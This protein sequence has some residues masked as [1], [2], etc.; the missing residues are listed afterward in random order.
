MNIETALEHHRAGRFAEAV[1]IYQQ[2]LQA[3]PDNADALH[4]LG[5][6]A[7]QLGDADAAVALISKAHALFPDNTVYLISLGMAYRQQRNFDIAM[8]CYE[9]VLEI[10][11]GSAS[12]YFG[13]ANTLQT[14]GRLDEAAQNFTYAL[15][16]NPGFVEARFNLANLEKSRGRYREA[17][18]HYRL[19]VAAKPDFADA[20][21][22]LGSALYAMGEA[23][24]ALA[25]YRQ[26]LGR[27]LPETHNNIGNIHF[28]CGDF[29]QALACYRQ[30][31]AAKPAYAEA[32]NNLGNALRKLGRFEESA[33]AFGEALRIQ[34][35]YATAHLNL[36]DLLLERDKVDEAAQHYQQAIAAA[37]GMAQA[38]FDLGVAR[39]LQDDPESAAACFAQAA[40]LSPDNIDAIYNLG[41]VCAKL[42]RPDEA[43]R[44]YRRVLELD[45]E[46]ID[47]HVNLSAL[48]TEA[49][50]TAEARSH[51][52]FA[53]RRKNL[54]E[55]RSPQAIKTVLLL[56][57]AGKGNMN[58]THLFNQKTNNII[59]W[60]V[61][62]AP[63]GQ[64]ANLPHYDLAFNAMGDPDV[65]GDTTEAVKR[66]LATTA[67]PLL[68]H[69]DK[70]ARTARDKLPA[71]LEGIPELLVPAVWRFADP[72]EWDPSLADRLPLLVR[73]VHTHGG[74]GMVLATS[75][76]ELARCR[77]EQSGPVYV[78]PFVDYRSPDSWFRKYRMIFI[79]RKPYPYH[80][81]V[82]QKWMVHYVT[83]D[84]EESPWRLAE[85][86]A[87]LENPEALVGSANMR[88]IRTIGERMDLDYAGLDFSILA[89]GRIL[90]FEANPTMLVHPEK[91]SGPLAHKN[92]Y[93][94]RIFG[95][96]EELL[97]R[98]VHLHSMGT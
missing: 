48:L 67:K 72:G 71:L 66:F 24:E 32:W 83:A 74:A 22:N 6:A 19:A 17:V 2:I 82:S 35:D 36:G 58:L 55:R 69:P 88:A 92:A 42:T 28:D 49:G 44:S 86:K 7:A 23:D 20:W 89:D 85:E 39:N 47:A 94:E 15:E 80:L 25:S 81:A 53:Y 43:E 65:T 38:H 56:L 87:Y 37:P 50:R 46:H 34:P 64:I 16:S 93:V 61:E 33:A 79:D 11:P 18:E 9:R 77:T 75:A 29:G 54:F 52:D 78:S 21:H 84:M 57:D 95:D 90:V 62:Y 63:P 73:P 70:V 1:Q 31:I 10:E 13:I 97:V 8:A 68:N 30:A 76:E 45:P 98:A 41:F 96:F 59:D 3:D 27:N 60:I 12:A 26:A 40:A 4:L 14:Q 51:L 5:N 91:Q